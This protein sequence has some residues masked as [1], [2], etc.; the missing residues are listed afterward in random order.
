MSFS[1]NAVTSIFF[2]HRYF[3]FRAFKFFFL[4]RASIK[5][6]IIITQQKM[7]QVASVNRSQLEEDNI[8]IA[9]HPRVIYLRRLYLMIALQLA[10]A[11]VCAY[12][13]IS[14][15]RNHRGPTATPPH[16]PH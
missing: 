8:L 15:K 5:N 3:P 6:F 1:Y 16:K 2:R 11:G 7:N 10:I 14:N 4:I 13:H 12:V 9:A